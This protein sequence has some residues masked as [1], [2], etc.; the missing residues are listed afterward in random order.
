MSPGCGST[1]SQ[2]RRT[3][4]VRACRSARR[5]SGCRCRRSSRWPT[6]QESGLPTARTGSSR[7]RAGKAPGRP[8]SWSRSSARRA[9]GAGPPLPPTAQTSLRL[10]A[11]TASRSLSRVGA[12]GRR[13]GPAGPVKV[14]GQGQHLAAGRGV[15]EVVAVPT[16]CHGLRRPTAQTGCRTRA[17]VA[18]FATLMCGTRPG[19]SPIP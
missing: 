7:C 14:L 19:S 18:A 15:V 13:D 8:A 2:R 16:L 5:G 12:G 1:G 9:R 17:P 6:R 3:A 10:T 11:C 4:A